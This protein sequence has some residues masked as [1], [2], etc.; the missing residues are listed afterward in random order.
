MSAQVIGIIGG[1]NFINKEHPIINVYK[2][3]VR[4]DR[5]INR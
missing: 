2:E 3:R 4:S 1:S 5:E